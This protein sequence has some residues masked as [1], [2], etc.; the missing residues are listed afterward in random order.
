MIAAIL[1][2][3][4]DWRDR[5]AV[6]RELRREKRRASPYESQEQA[7]LI[8]QIQNAAFREDRD[9]ALVAWNALYALAPDIAITSTEAVRA[10][11]WLKHFQQVEAA[12]IEAQERFPR[13]ADLAR[14]YAESA[15][16]QG[17]WEIACERW[18][19]VRRLYPAV[20]GG[21][22][23]GAGALS[24]LGHFEEAEKLL[25]YWTKIDPTDIVGASEYAKVAEQ[26]GNLPAALERWRRMQELIHD[27]TAWIGEAQILR[28]LDRKDDAIA[29]LERARWKFDSSPLPTMELCLIVQ[30][31]GN[32]EETL[33]QWQ[34]FRDHFPASTAGYVFAAWVL[35]DLQR[36][37]EAEAILRLYI[38]RDLTEPEPAIEYARLAHGR[39]EWEEAARRWKSVREKFPDCREAYEWG[40]AALDNL[41]EPEKAS[42]LR[43]SAP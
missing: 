32:H 9:A 23:F 20:G 17:K 18:A 27:V 37:D 3:F 12:L 2:R 7:R 31:E 28:K 38:D 8:N 30:A 19:E 42:E 13:Q 35:R 26:I 5:R 6:F 24:V 41:G 16:H 33:R 21:Y 39:Q 25:E 11:I 1:E 43:S 10:M 36:H 15:Q 40:A 4:R 14:L 34:R 22:T 29:V